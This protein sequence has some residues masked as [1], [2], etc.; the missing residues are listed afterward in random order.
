VGCLREAKMISYVTAV[1]FS[2]RYDGQG[3]SVG[4]VSLLF[5]GRSPAN[6][7]DSANVGVQKR[8]LDTIW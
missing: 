6:V 4:I 5:G 3:V 2:A 8:K 1:F 7:Q